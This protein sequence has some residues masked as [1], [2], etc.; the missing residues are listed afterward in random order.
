MGLLKLISRTKEYKA[1]WNKNLESIIADSKERDKFDF[2]FKNI[3]RPGL[4][5]AGYGAVLFSELFKGL[6]ILPPL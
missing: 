2:R 6:M 1:L 4:G 5:F 3:E